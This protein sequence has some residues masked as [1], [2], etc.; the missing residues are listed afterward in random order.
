M[1]IAKGKGDGVGK[2]REWSG[3]PILLLYFTSTCHRRMRKCLAEGNK[4]RPVEEWGRRA[5]PARKICSQDSR[6]Q[7]RRAIHGNRKASKLQREY[8]FSVRG[9]RE[10]KVSRTQ[11]CCVSLYECV[12][13]RESNRGVDG[14]GYSFVT[15]Y[16]CDNMQ[17]DWMNFVYRLSA[18][19][20]PAESS[21]SSKTKLLD[22]PMRRSLFEYVKHS[23]NKKHE[24]CN[25]S[26]DD[27]PINR[28]IVSL[29]DY[30]SDTVLLRKFKDLEVCD[31]IAI[32]KFCELINVDVNTFNDSFF[33][34]IQEIP[35]FTSSLIII[36]GSILK[37]Q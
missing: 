32:S 25:M 22:G 12:K 13:C 34:V 2:R 7:A 6:A 30:R 11:P 14:T 26:F 27:I 15:Q 33:N 37:T 31:Y 8:R 10:N 18:T 29:I 9:M 28:S 23:K 35:Y 4:A 21:L 19:V 36:K 24:L 20:E 5:E 1:K 3:I 16:R 17:R